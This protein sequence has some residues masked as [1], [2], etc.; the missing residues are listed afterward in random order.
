[1]G[2]FTTQRRTAVFSPDRK[3]RYGLM[4]VWEVDLPILV[5]IF[6][7]PSK[8]DE[9]IE[10]NTDKLFRARAQALGY[11]GAYMLNLF[12]LVSTNPQALKETKDPVGK[13]NDH[14]IVQTCKGHKHI[15]CGWGTN[16]AY[17]NRAAQ[18]LAL[19]H[20]KLNPQPTLF[21]LKLTQDGHPAHPL[22]IKKNTPMTPWSIR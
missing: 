1:M 14:Y 19:L 21:Y 11:G 5:G 15:L 9:R 6:C 2:L 22:Y 13:N 20:N 16:G 3:Y 7:N 18:V 4:T 12:A 8:A 17:L 10:D